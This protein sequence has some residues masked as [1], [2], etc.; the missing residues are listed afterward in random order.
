MPFGL[1]IRPIAP[2]VAAMSE[3]SIDFYNA[4]VDAIQAGRLDE[5]LTAAENSLT[6][7]PKDAETW[8][9]YVI[10]LNALGRSEDAQKA[11]AKLSEL[12]LGEADGF[13]LQAAQ[14]ASSGDLTTAIS[15]YLSALGAGG[16]RP[17]IHAGYALALMESGRPDEALDAA[18][19]AVSLAPDDARANY[20]LGHIL[21]LRGENDEALAALTLAVTAEPDLMLAVY[22]QGMLLAEKD[23]LEEALENF[24]RYLKSNS[25][26]PSA[27]QAVESIRHRMR[28]ETR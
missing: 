8:Q 7:N 20:A 24:T 12:G 5:A 1:G 25:G 28:P 27:V 6:E 14:A 23:R 15:H 13:L 9:L 16:E 10:V 17:E 19:K 18:L 22:E 4:A 2:I 3:P 11:T 26:D 21:R